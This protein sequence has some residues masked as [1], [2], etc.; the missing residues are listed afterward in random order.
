MTNPQSGAIRPGSRTEPARIPIL[1]YSDLFF[2]QK[3]AVK[4]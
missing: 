3:T 1:I 4:I 2:K